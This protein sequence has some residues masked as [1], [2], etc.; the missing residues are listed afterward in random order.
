MPATFQPY[1]AEKFID[2]GQGAVNRKI[3]KQPIVLV[4]CALNLEKAALLPTVFSAMRFK[5]M[6]FHRRLAKLGAADIT[7]AL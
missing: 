7:V 3:D 5:Y 4:V 6:V 2:V 1:F